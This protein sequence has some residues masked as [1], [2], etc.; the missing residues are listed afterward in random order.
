VFARGANS[1]K[2]RPILRKSLK[3]VTEQVESR[4]ADWIDPSDPAKGI[5]CREKIYFGPRELPVE[6]IEVNSIPADAGLK[7]VRPKSWRNPTLPR[8]H[9]A[10]M[11]EAAPYWDWSSEPVPA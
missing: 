4:R 1:A 7:V 9:S 6:T 2:D 8:L 3:Y 10:P 11:L 5:I